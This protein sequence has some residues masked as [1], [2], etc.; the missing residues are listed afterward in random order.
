MAKAIGIA[1]AVLLAS[2]VGLGMYQV[3]MRFVIM[4]PSTWSEALTRTLLIWMVYLGAAL[5]VRGGLL[6]AV[7]VVRSGV[8]GP[9]RTALELVALLACLVFFAT[10]AWY[11][12][13]I[14]GRVRFQVLAGLEVSI[15][16]AYAALPVGCTIAALTAMF[17]IVRLLSGVSTETD[18]GTAR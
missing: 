12:Y 7:D 13:L 16:W 1:V 9:L 14:A 17:S 11:G 4:Q 6:V 18:R 15:A 10:V 3:L 5:A 8:R 2:S